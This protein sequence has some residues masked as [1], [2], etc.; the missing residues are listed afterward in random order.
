MFSSIEFQGERASTSFHYEPFS[1]GTRLAEL[2]R[3]TTIAA[4]N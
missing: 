1:S 3:Q 2:V 4:T